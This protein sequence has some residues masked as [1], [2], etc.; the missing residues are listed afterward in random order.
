MLKIMLKNKNCTQSIIT[1]Y[2]QIGMNKSL[3]IAD[4]LGRLFYQGAF[5]KEGKIYSCSLRQ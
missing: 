3:L 2:I 4:N 5:I 1:I